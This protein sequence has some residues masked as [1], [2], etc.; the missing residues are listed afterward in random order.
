MNNRNIVDPSAWECTDV[1][2]AEGNIV[3]RT[4]RSSKV[5]SIR[6][7]LFQ[8]NARNE[9]A[10]HHN[11]ASVPVFTLQQEVQVLK[12][13]FQFNSVATQYCEYGKANK[14]DW[15]KD[16]LAIL[17]NALRSE[18]LDLITLLNCLKKLAMKSTISDFDGIR[19]WFQVCSGVVLD[20][21]D[22]ESKYL[23]P[24]I[25]EAATQNDSLADANKFFSQMP[26]RQQQI[27]DIVMSSSKSFGDLCNAG[28]TTSKMTNA[29]MAILIMGGLD[30]LVYQLFDYMLEQEKHLPPLLTSVYKS[31]KKEREAIMRKILKF[32]TKKSRRGDTTLVLFTRWIEDSKRQ[33]TLV[34]ELQIVCAVNFAALQS[35]FEMNHAG[36]IHQFRVKAGMHSE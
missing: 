16:I 20:Y 31:E 4:T 36:F 26:T 25:Q 6:S 27:R 11:S 1:G 5:S 3:N 33:K 29:Q 10:A 19:N 24:W 8:K 22:M 13:P 30:A 28:Q 34:K 35:Q 23:F 12:A 17:H 14:K 2:G 18:L 15:T 32:I 9:A 21:C 7:S